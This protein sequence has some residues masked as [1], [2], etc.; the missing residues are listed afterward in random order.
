[1]SARTRRA[2]K[3][4]DVLQRDGDRRLALLFLATV[5][6]DVGAG[7][8]GQVAQHVG[9]RLILHVERDRMPWAWSSITSGLRSGEVSP[10]SA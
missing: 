9:E 5:E 4:A 2:V 1:M 8:V 10:S 6:D 3:Q 7:A